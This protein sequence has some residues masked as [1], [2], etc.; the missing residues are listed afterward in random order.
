MS[1]LQLLT[2]LQ[3]AKFDS[4]PTFTSELR[5]LYFEINEEIKEYIDGMR[6]LNNKIGFVLQ[7]GYFR[8]SG[9]FFTNDRFR[10]ADIKFISNILEISPSI[11]NLNI[12]VYNSKSRSLHK[13]HILEMSGWQQFA[14]EHYDDL[15]TEL[16]L[17]A[18]QQMHPK[19]LLPITY[20]N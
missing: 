14:K 12:E 10:S 1:K 9:K 5:H 19:S 4:C 2:Q 18:K 16:S 15:S 6:N 11:F 20:C 17:H 7:L 13:K 8:A 3:Q